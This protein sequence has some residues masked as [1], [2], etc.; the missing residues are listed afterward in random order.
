MFAIH[1]LHTVIPVRRMASESSGGYEPNESKSIS[2]HEAILVLSCEF[3][4]HVHVDV[5]VY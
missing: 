1:S 3:V 2:R 4:I 5:H